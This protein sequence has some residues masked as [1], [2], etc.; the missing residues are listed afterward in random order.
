M[1]NTSKPSEEFIGD[2]KFDL[3]P[4]VKVKSNIVCFKGIPNVLT[5]N[6]KETLYEESNEDVIFNLD[7]K[8]KVKMNIVILKIINFSSLSGLDR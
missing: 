2:V 5:T 3:G 7:A 8:I 6:R 1:T 4:N